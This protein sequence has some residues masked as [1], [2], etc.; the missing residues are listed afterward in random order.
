MRVILT[1]ENG[2]YVMRKEHVN[3]ITLDE[4]SRLRRE[5]VMQR[6]AEQRRKQKQN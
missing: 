4:I 3:V 6:E 1:I 2:R 5:K